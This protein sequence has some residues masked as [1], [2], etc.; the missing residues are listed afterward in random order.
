MCTLFRT[1]CV[2]CYWLPCQ[3]LI[4]PKPQHFHEFSRVIKVESLDKKW[5][6]RTVWTWNPVSYILIFNPWFFTLRPFL[7]AWVLLECKKCVL[8]TSSSHEKM[9]VTAFLQLLIH[10]SCPKISL[11]SNTSDFQTVRVWLSLQNLSNLIEKMWLGFSATSLMKDEAKGRRYSLSSPSS[12][13]SKFY[14]RV[15]MLAQP[16]FG[17]LLAASE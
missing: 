10:R 2:L 17:K 9:K 7:V 15:L 8:D 16:N 12:N 5:R 3:Q 6:F 4:C 14:Q 13:F 11:L 1:P